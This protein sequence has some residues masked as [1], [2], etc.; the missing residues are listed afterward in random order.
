LEEV[1]RNRAA[2]I[3]RLKEEAAQQEASRTAANVPLQ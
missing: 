1:Q 3:E 2:V